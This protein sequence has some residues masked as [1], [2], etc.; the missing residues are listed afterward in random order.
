MATRLN[1]QARALL[2]EFL[3]RFEE[4]IL[5]RIGPALERVGSAGA[6]MCPAPGCRRPGA[7]PRNRFFCREHARSLSKSA[8]D[9]I[10]AKAR[11]DAPREPPSARGARISSR[12]KPRGPLDM[13]CRADGCKNKSRGPR[14]GFICD[15]HRKTLG[16]KQQQEAREK[17]K[18]RRAAAA[19][20][21]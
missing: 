2:G 15:E 17:Y 20:K 19:A 9:R 11:R 1:P 6:R 10:L 18:A 13:N 16:K 5:E 3:T 12:R 7:G 21:A 4:A 8:Q 14:F